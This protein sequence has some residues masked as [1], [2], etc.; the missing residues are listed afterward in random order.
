M[1]AGGAVAEERK[2][3]PVAP[4]TAT[5][6]HDGDAEG[7]EGSDGDAKKGRGW[8]HLAVDAGVLFWCFVLPIIAASVRELVSC[9]R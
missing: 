2:Q 7:K 9:Q 4:A 3:D 1:C 5:T 8:L 6:G